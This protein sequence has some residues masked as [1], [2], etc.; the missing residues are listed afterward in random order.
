MV[1]TFG[2]VLIAPTAQRARARA[3]VTVCSVIMVYELSCVS[4]KTVN[5]M[6]SGLVMCVLVVKRFYTAL[7]TAGLTD[8]Y[9]HQHN[10]TGS[11]ADLMVGL[12]AV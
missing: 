4:L 12:C 11:G 1:A 6:S 8:F 10:A 5:G 2:A 3:K 9:L 7:M